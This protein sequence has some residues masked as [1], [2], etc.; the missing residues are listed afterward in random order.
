M[1]L[2]ADIYLLLSLR[3]SFK[4]RGE[5][6]A[7]DLCHR[8]TL[9]KSL[10]RMEE[11][12]FILKTPREIDGRYTAEFNLTRKGRE[13]ASILASFNIG[14]IPE[15]GLTEQ[16]WRILNSCAERR[17]FGD[18]QRELEIAEPN[19]DRHLKILLSVG[20]V[21]KAEDAYV[22]TPGGRDLVQALEA[23]VP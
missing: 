21:Q 1:L 17:R 12:G 3:D 20:L 7:E 6:E 9:S 15:T 23:K 22:L 18:L 19:V 2:R 16:R 14:E 13:I 5:L 4:T 11:V 10:R 8:D